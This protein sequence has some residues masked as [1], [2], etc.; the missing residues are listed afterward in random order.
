MMKNKI[1]VGILPVILL[2][3]CGVKNKTDEESKT[4]STEL[5]SSVTE[6]T[7]VKGNTTQETTQKILNATEEL[8]QQYP[9]QLFPTELSY[10]GNALNAISEEKGQKITVFYVSGKKA[11]PLNDKKIRSKDAFAKYTIQTY[12]SKEEAAKE[13]EEDVVEDGLPVS[14]GYGITGY[15]QGAAGS[16]YLNWREGNWHLSVQTSNIEGEDPVPFAKD[17]VEFLEKNFL[18]V[19]ESLGEISFNLATKTL[20]SNQ[21]KLQKE[22]V[23]Y[24]IEHQEPLAI[25]KMAVSLTK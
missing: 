12:G 13:F 24:T 22:N 1:I 6:T 8:Y 18:P 21:L 15:R 11:Y 3:A 17:V 23:V 4:T 2:G 5:T 20:D 16:I 9:T 10:K 19:P 7:T 25:L 14:L